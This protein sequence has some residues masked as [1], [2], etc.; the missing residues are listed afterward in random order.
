MTQNEFNAMLKVALEEVKLSVPPDSVCSIFS[1]IIDNI[2]IEVEPKPAKDVSFGC[3]TEPILYAS[4]PLTPLGQAQMELSK[5]KDLARHLHTELSKY[6]S[7]VR[8]LADDYIKYVVYYNAEGHRIT[9][10]KI[11][12]IAGLSADE[13]WGR[14][15]RTVD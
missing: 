3:R 14:E 8:K 10:Q 1:I 5:S 11:A 13:I 6:K 4:P 7:A 9:K 15:S 2:K 12:D